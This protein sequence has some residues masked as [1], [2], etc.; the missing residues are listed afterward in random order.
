LQGMHWVSAY[1]DQFNIRVLN[2]SWGTPSTQ[3]PALD[4]LNYAVERLWQQGIA[5]E[6]GVPVVLRVQGVSSCVFEQDAAGGVEY[7]HGRGF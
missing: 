6:Q 4:P 3:S 5:V 7:L 1:K 2:L